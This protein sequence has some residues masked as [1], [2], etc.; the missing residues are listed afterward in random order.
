MFTRRETLSTIMRAGAGVYGLHFLTA[1]GTTD[2]D[3]G[4]TIPWPKMDTPPILGGDPSLPWWARDNYAPVS[5]EIE[6]FDLEVHGSIP[7]E[8]NGFFLRNGPN[9]NSTVPDFWFFGDGMLHSVELSNGRALSYRNKWVQ[10]DSFASGRSTL[11]SNYGNTSLLNHGNR[12]LALY[13]QGAPFEIELPSLNTIGRYDFNVDFNQSMTAHPKI[14]PNTGDIHFF[15][16]APFP[17]LSQIL[18]VIFA[19]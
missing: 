6:T 11:F 18:C 13:E 16:Y 5:D 1:C 10:T 17:S 8:L 12:L 9:S 15:G 7:P 19:G 4:P 2:S 3:T 14:D